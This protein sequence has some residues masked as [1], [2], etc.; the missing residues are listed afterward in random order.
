M[1]LA[2]ET[3]GGF[4]E[5]GITQKEEKSLGFGGE[6]LSDRESRLG[7]GSMVWKRGL[8]EYSSGEGSLNHKKT[9]AKFLKNIPLW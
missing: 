8:E 9:L 1:S 6:G 3:E 7:Q 2:S 5:G 4:T